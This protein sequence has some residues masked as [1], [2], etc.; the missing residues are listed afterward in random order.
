MSDDY[1][2]AATFDAMHEASKAKR[3]RNR[4]ASARLLR[5][6][7]I[8]FEERN[9]GAHLIVAG[10]YDFWPGTG[11]WMARGEK[12]KRRG[13]KELIARITRDPGIDDES[14]NG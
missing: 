4:E 10:R 5:E 8:G 9:G 7:G 12:T 2:M 1:D 13:V 14:A 3:A 6:A 11:L